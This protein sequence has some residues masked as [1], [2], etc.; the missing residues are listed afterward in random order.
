[1]SYGWVLNYLGCDGWEDGLV[2]GV[3]GVVVVEGPKGRRLF[4]GLEGL[5]GDATALC[6]QWEHLRSGEGICAWEGGTSGLLLLLLLSLLC[7]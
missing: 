4:G 7:C 2:G 5:G 6:E 1:M 3:R